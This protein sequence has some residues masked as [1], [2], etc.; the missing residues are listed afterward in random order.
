MRQIKDIYYTDAKSSECSLDILLPDE[1]IKASNKIFVYFHGGSLK[2]GDKSD[3]LSFAPFLTSNGIAI[4]SANYRM[5]P[6]AKYP[7]FL[8]DSAAAVAWICKHIKQYGDYSEIYVG[9]SSAGGYISM[10][11]CFDKSYLNIH[12]IDPDSLAGFIH[13]AGQPTCHFNVLRERNIDSRRIIVDESAPIWHI[14]TRNIRVPMLFI[15]SDN[16]LTNRYEQTMM[17]LKTLEHFN[18][19][20]SKIKSIVLHGSHCHY[21]GTTDENGINIFGKTVYEFIG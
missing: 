14:G 16:D 10:M 11:L 8:T 18:H 21:L 9:G 5:Y 7:E 15:V 13:D 17:L 20:M 12:G 1:S 4:A 3:A 19:D 2:S 6:N